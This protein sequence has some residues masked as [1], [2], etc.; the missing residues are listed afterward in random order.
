[1][2]TNDS[3]LSDEKVAALEGLVTKWKAEVDN[4]SKREKDFIKDGCKLVELYEGKDKEGTQYNILYANTETL[5]P[6]LYNSTPRPVV[7]R[8]FKDEDPVGAKAATAGQRLLEY[9]LDDGMSEYANFDD[10]MKQA[11][12][13]ALVPGRG[14]LWFKYDPKFEKVQQAEAGEAAAEAI[15]EGADPAEGEAPARPEA[16]AEK[17]SYETVCGDHVPWDRFRCGY[18]KKWADVPWVGRDHFMT[19][20]ELKENFGEIGV[21]VPVEEI[22]STMTGNDDSQ[23]RVDGMEGVKGAWVHEIWDRVTKRV[24]FFAPNFPRAPLRVVDDPLGLEGFFPCPKPLT[25]IGKIS[26]LTPVA[27]YT[28][29]EKQAQELNKLTLRINKLIDSL[30][31]RGMYDTTVQGLD[32]VLGA[33]DAVLIP[34]ENV[35]AMLSQ[36][37]GL[38]KSIWLVPIEKIFPVVQSLYAQRQQCKSIIYELTGIADI[39]RGSTQASETLGAQELKTQWGTLRLKRHQKEVAR[40]ARDCLRIMLE[41]AVSKLAPETISAMTG[42]PYPTGSQ[43]AQMAAA[44]QEAQAAGMEIPPAV[45]A[46]MDEPSWDDL[47]ALL[48]NDVQ[49]SYRID[50]ETNSTVDMEATE[51]KEQ[52]AELLNAISQFLNGVAPLVEQGVMPFEVSRDMLLM[53]TRRFRFGAEFEESLKKMSAPQAK[54]DP[55]AEADLKMKQIEMQAKQQEADRKQAESQQQAAAKEREM[56]MQLEFKEKEHNMRLR[57]LDLNMAVKEREHELA[58]EKIQAQVLA[59][60]MMPKPAPGAKKPMK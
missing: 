20:E 46:M 7:T 58:L 4:S 3:N 25:F 17:V 24:I 22:S 36:G 57:E 51:D 2:D 5:A 60:R 19:A 42:L 47:L 56:A 29:Y 48:R 9:L 12:L 23:K 44:M 8:R 6:S 16:V 33:D 18:A 59:A 21:T 34:V 41:I 35:A 40:Y 15:G 50:V 30:K 43:K 49:R 14:V 26:N 55:K 37:M 13:E 52:I 1:M 45:A 11:V 39:M 54:P 27:L 32:K 53:V 38:D 31:V 28:L 10:L